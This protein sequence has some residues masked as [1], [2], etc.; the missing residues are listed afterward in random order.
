MFDLENSLKH[1]LDRVIN[2][3]AKEIIETKKGDFDDGALF[4]IRVVLSAIKNDII[5]YD[6]E[7]VKR[8]GLDFDIDRTIQ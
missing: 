7:M 4:G 5:P 6:E 2:D 8:L 1:S 3:H